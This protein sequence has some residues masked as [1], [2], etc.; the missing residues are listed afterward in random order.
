MTGVGGGWFWSQII[1]VLPDMRLTAFVPT[2]VDQQ[3]PLQ[4]S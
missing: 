4:L 2:R 1:A 3:R